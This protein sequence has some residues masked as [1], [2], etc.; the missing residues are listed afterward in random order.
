MLGLLDLLLAALVGTT[1]TYT[2]NRRLANRQAKWLL[3]QKKLDHIEEICREL[4]AIVITYWSAP[5]TNGNRL[6]MAAC[7]VKIDAYLP[8]IVRFIN[9]NFARDAY[10]RQIVDYLA[11]EITLAGFTGETRAADIER[12]R[13]GAALILRIIRLISEE[14]KKSDR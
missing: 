4:L 10:A 2:C 8:E 7:E 5:I 14:R 12:A 6:D 13:I 11:N 1:A 9:E 3:R